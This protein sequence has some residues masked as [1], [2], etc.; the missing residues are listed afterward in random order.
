MV[1][2]GNVEGTRLDAGAD[3]S[4]SQAAPQIDGDA[5]AHGGSQGGQVQLGAQQTA[6]PPKETLRQDHHKK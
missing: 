4:L 5:A 6:T 1:R 3:A 2:G